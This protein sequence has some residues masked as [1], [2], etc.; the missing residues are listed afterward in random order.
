[1][2]KKEKYLKRQEL[3]DAMGFSKHMYYSALEEGMPWY[4][5]G[6]QKVHLLSECQTWMKSRKRSER[7]GA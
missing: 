4:P 5:L 2:S 6:K 3:M 1:M 7:K